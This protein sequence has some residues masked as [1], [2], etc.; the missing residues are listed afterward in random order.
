MTIEITYRNL[1]ANTP[2]YAAI[3]LKDSIG[4]WVLASMSQRSVSLTQDEWM[5]R[6]YPLGLFTTT[7]KLP[8]NFLNEGEYFVTAIVGRDTNNTQALMEDV[9]SFNVHDTGEMRGQDQHTQWGGVVR[10][11]LAWNTQ[12]IV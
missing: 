3:W 1:R 11:K 8:G 9:I 10:P 7:C 12:M 5:G 2:L 6:E 4:T